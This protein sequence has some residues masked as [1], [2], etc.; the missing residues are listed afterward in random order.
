MAHPRIAVIGSGIGGTSAA[1]HLSQFSRSDRGQASSLSRV[2]VDTFEGEAHIGGHA[3]QVELDG[4]VLDLGFMMYGDSNPNIKQWFQDELR[5]T[6]DKGQS[7][8]TR[9]WETM[10]E[11]SDKGSVSIETQIPLRDGTMGV[12]LDKRWME[13][14]GDTLH[15][16]VTLSK[17]NGETLAVVDRL[18]VRTQSSC[19]PV[20][21]LPG[22]TGEEGAGGREGTS[23]SALSRRRAKRRAKRLATGTQAKP[24]PN[25]TGRYSVLGH[26]FTISMLAIILGLSVSAY[27]DNPMT[28]QLQN[29]NGEVV[30]TLHWTTICACATFVLAFVIAQNYMQ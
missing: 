8:E 29:A 7:V 24:K 9:A 5:L 18:L 13:D 21:R 27:Q 23:A 20:P 14:S 2:A 26:L 1:W 4:E 22:A 6:N 3:Y 12:M 15:R 25:L 16:V 11:G 17:R 28:M 10:D 30:T 19:T